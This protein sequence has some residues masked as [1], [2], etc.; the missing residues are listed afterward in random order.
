MATENGKYNSKNRFEAS[1]L[2]IVPVGLVRPDV[3]FLN[4]MRAQRVEHG[5]IPC[6]A[7]HIVRLAGRAA[8]PEPSIL[9]GT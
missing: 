2:Q 6:H 7:G 1:D 8:K 5:H 4:N 9:V 3:R